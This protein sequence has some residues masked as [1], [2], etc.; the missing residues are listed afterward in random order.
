ML[1]AMQMSHGIISGGYSKVWISLMRKW[2][3]LIRVDPSYW[4]ER[5]LSRELHF[6]KIEEPTRILKPAELVKTAGWESKETKGEDEKPHGSQR[7]S[8]KGKTHQHHEHTRPFSPPS[9]EVSFHHHFIHSAKMWNG[10]S[11]SVVRGGS[12]IFQ[13]FQT[14][15]YRSLHSIIPSRQLYLSCSQ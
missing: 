6:H 2:P 11:R 8:G 14:T 9:R 15:G 3:R 13:L 5:S 4:M 12:K 1:K 10:E 7:Q